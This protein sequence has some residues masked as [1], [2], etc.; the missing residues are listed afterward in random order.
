MKS[1]L[2]VHPSLE[3][4]AQQELQEQAHISSTIHPQ[5]IEF[6][7]PP[8][9]LLSL[10]THLQTPRR[11]LL[12]LGQFNKADDIN[13]LSL[14]L[15][16]KDIFTNELTFKIEVEN[17]PGID[18]RLALSKAAATKFYQALAPTSLNPQINLK[19]PD[20]L[21]IIY[22]N[23]DHF[24]VGI[25][26]T[27]LELNTRSYRV[28][29]HQS[30]FKGDLAYY[31]LRQSTFSPEKKTLLGFAKDGSIA[32]EAALFSSHTPPHNPSTFSCTKFP[33]MQSLPL[34]F[35][36]PTSHPSPPSPPS[37]KNSIYVFD[38]T[39]QNTTAIRKNALIAKVNSVLTIAKH[40][41]DEVD[42]KYDP[43]SFDIALFQVTSKDE[44]K[45][46]DLYY[47]VDYILKPR[48]ILFIIGRPTWDF[49]L[50]QKF[51]LIEQQDITK[52]SSTHRYWKLQK[53]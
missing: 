21:I 53:K 40:P 28:F 17:L 31:F 48:G 26:L 9:T 5:V 42:L 10:A 12:A 34:S 15:N 4:I 24:F 46:N 49:P 43:A 25:D 32:I 14:P 38:E 45:I 23:Q 16:L 18:N 22:A 37:I 51:N 39:T 36:S 7:S 41:L 1:Y 27:G 13:F 33:L 20:I 50:S 6:D 47:S 35:T 19:H 2:L 30:S 44:E 29:P 52:G 8:Q 11:I 3:H